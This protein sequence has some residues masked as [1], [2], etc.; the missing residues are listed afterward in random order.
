MH[1]LSGARVSIPTATVLFWMSAPFLDLSGWQAAAAGIFALVGIF[2][3]AAVTLLTFAANERL[4]PTVAG[5][6]GSTAPLFAVFGAALFLSEPLGARELIATA[7]IL[8][9]VLFLPYW[10]YLPLIGAA[11]I[12]LPLYWEA[13]IFGFLIDALYGAGTFRLALIATAV[14]LALL[15]VRERLRF[16]F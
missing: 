7:V 4:G 3:P 14:L 13:I 8:F 2:F 11:M 5:T 15:P 9:S 12:L 16:S 10:V 1:A 6:I